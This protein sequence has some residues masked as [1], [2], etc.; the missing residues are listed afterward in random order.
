M[1]VNLLKQHLYPVIE[2]TATLGIGLFTKEHQRGRGR[3]RRKEKEEGEEG[4]GTTKR[5][6]RSIRSVSLK[7]R[8]NTLTLEVLQGT[9]L[10]DLP[11]RCLNVSDT[12]RK[13]AHP[14][15]LHLPLAKINFVSI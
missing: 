1:V 10:S 14:I 6:R 2:S 3:R 7:G 4:R 12:L 13:S 8:L 11:L 15:C 9:A 5:R